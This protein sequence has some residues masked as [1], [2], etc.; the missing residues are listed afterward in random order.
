MTPQQSLGQRLKAWRIANS[1]SLGEAAERCHVPAVVLEETE[2]GVAVYPL[3]AQRIEA[4]I[5]PNTDMILEAVVE[6]VRA[7]L[8]RGVRTIE[9]V[10]EATEDH[11][12]ITIILRNREVSR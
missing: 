3:T 11:G 12:K 5:T 9:I 1:L 8:A 2:N 10:Q 4:L 7:G 6:A